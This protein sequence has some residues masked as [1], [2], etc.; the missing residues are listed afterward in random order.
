MRYKRGDELLLKVKDTF[1]YSDV[2]YRS[3]KVQVIGFNVDCDGPDAE[4]LVYV[5]SYSYVKS[6]FVLTQRHANWYSVDA[7]FIGDN[8]MFIT[9]KHPIYKRIPA[10][11]GERCD[12]CNEF[13]EGAVRSENDAYMCRACRENPWR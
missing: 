12:R 10:V 6:S 1:G 9:A 2:T 11:E 4:Y 7:K 5:P 3:V 8:V 13:C